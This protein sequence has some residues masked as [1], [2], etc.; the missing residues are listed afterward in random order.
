MTAAPVVLTRTLQEAILRALALI[1]LLIL[2]S[3]TLGQGSE[4]MQD[5][6]H[7]LTEVTDFSADGKTAGQ[8]KT[9]IL[10]LVSQD[11]CPFCDQIKREILGPMLVSGEY[12]RKV[13]IREI[14]IDL[15]SRVTDFTGVTREASSFMLNYKVYLTPTLLFLDD[16]GRELTER[17][18]GIQ[19]PELYPFYVDRAVEKAIAAYREKG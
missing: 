9:P 2:S 15:G 10:L 7:M 12:D 13:M 8:N 6:K 4:D 1:S 16:E 18:V 3:L 19:T 17:M 5:F 11:H 14:Y